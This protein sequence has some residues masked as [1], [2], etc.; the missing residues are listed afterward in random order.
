MRLVDDDDASIRLAAP[1]KRLDGRHLNARLPVRQRVVGLHCANVMDAL[2]LEGGDRLI[3]ERDARGDE[4]SALPAFK[5]LFDD[6][7]REQ[8][9]SEAGW[10]LNQR[11]LSSERQGLVEHFER[12]L[13]V[14]A[15]RLTNGS[16]GGASAFK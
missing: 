3:D 6:A 7:R 12:A 16:A 5:G 15:Q 4:Q 8:G 14:R 10:R 2:H 1:R 13:L 11:A 9:L